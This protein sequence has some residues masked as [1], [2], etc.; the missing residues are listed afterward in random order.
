MKNLQYIINDSYAPLSKQ[1]NNNYEER[2]GAK[3][4]FEEF[5]EKKV[6]HKFYCWKYIRGFIYIFTTPIYN[7]LKPYELFNV[8]MRQEEGIPV[9]LV[10]RNDELQQILDK[11]RLYMEVLLQTLTVKKN[12]VFKSDVEFIIRLHDKEVRDYV[13]VPITSR[14]RF[15]EVYVGNSKKMN[16]VANIF[17]LMTKK[18]EEVKAILAEPGHN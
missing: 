2:I 13:D 5:F 1:K 8:E 18:L 11:S 17:M 9:K 15:N 3:R 10:R 12:D 7:F 14:N 16:P 6:R 4:V